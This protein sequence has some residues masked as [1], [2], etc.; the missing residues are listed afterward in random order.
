LPQNDP[1]EPAKKQKMAGQHPVPPTMAALAAVATTPP[2]VSPT[3]PQ[4]SAT[5]RLIPARTEMFLF[6]TPIAFFTAVSRRLEL[7]AES[8]M[9]SSTSFSE[10]VEKNS[11]ANS[12]KIAARRR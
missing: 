11:S 10:N 6:K 8:D 5:K 3:H 9:M 4:P 1:A 7:A 12:E 2:T